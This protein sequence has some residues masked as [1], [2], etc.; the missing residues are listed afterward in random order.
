MQSRA[1]VGV[2]HHA[3]IEFDG[4]SQGGWHRCRGSGDS[5]PVLVDPPQVVGQVGT[6]RTEA[7]QV[8]ETDRRVGPGD[9]GIRVQVAQQT[10]GQPVRQRP[11]LF[12]GA[13]DNRPQRGV[14]GHHLRPGQLTH[15]E[16]HR[17]LTGEPADGSGQIRIGHE[18]FVTA[19]PFDIDAN[20]RSGRA[21]KLVPGQGESDQQHVLNPSVICDRHLAQ[22]LA[23]E[24]SVQR[25]RQLPGTGIGVHGGVHG[26]Q[27]RRNLL[28][29]P[30]GAGQRLHIGGAC[31]LV[32][33]TRPPG[34]RRA[35][36]GQFHRLP[37]VVLR[38][39]DV[40]VFQQDPPRHRIDSQVVDDQHQAILAALP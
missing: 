6:A 10:V 8:V 28:H 18:L 24:I 15:R 36:R 30:P 12:F 21:Q 29:L 9:I 38:P 26:R 31:A 32:E 13:L 22:Q 5:H 34:K 27:R 39:G 16:R 37:S 20:R 2:F 33:Q 11:K 23:G 17:V 7:A 35:A 19:M 4:V 25:Y 1:R 40:E 3:R 14:T